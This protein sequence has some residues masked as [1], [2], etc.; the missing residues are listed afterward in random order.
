MPTETYSF[1]A[2]INQLMSLIINTFYSNKDIYLRELISNASDAIDK[3]KYN[4]LQSENVVRDYYIKLVADKEKHTLSIEDNGIG[5][6]KQD[7]ID[8]LGTVANS[9]TKQFMQALKEGTDVSLIGQFGVGFYSAYLVADTVSVY[10]GNHCWESK[11]GGSFTIEYSETPFIENGT[12]LVLH[13][14]ED[15]LD[16]LEQSN[17]EQIV[18]THS[19]YINYPISLWIT[20]TETKEVPDD[21]N[22][23]VQDESNETD[24][25]V[26]IEDV[27]EEI[28]EWKQINVQKPLWMRKPE[29]VNEEEHASFYKS[30][31]KDWDS[32]LA[33]KHFVAEGQI[34]FKSLLYIPK[35]SPHD[36]FSN[37][38]K[39]N[40][41]KLYVK[42]VFIMDNCE[43]LMP[44][45]LNFMSGVVDSEDL[46]LNISREILQQNKI[47]NV[48]KK[49]LVKKC[50][51]LFNELMEK[52]D[53]SLY[54]TFYDNYHQSLKLGVHEDSVNRDKLIKLLC[55]QTK[56]HT[57]K[58]ALSQYVKEM[59]SDQEHI[60]FITGESRKAV[61]NS[62]FVKG[63][64][65][66]GFD[67]V[68]FVDPIDE[69]MVQQVKEFES[70]K[71]LNISKDNSIF[72]EKN[73]DY[74]THLCKVLKNN[75]NIEKVVV[76]T[77]LG[78]DPCC[79]V[80]S[81]YGWSANMERIMKAQ[82]LQNNM[83]M[84]M[85][86]GSK[87]ILEVNPNHKLIQKLQDGIKNS[88]ISDKSIKDISNLIY[89]TAL[90]SS[91]FTHED[92]SSFSKRIYN[93]IAVGLDVEETT[94]TV[95]DTTEKENENMESEKIENE[96]MV[97]ESMEEID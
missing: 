52:E 92:P 96:N 90:L 34:E 39:K 37:K 63:I 82:T 74:E 21:S 33:H 78:E 64:I 86:Q 23:D 72:Q 18:H 9:G 41:I 46:P 85:M 43:E 29:D 13:M 61:E 31:T 51:E 60:Y 88:S 97:E 62:P 35:R 5:L 38:T 75:L 91:G 69:Y 79:L 24:S 4:A 14:K 10:S 70:V 57:S 25:N 22:D 54:N 84:G 53:K 66:K 40:N 83:H 81:E 11:A 2:E 20:R 58:I 48:I 27:S 47:T 8:C 28:Q 12:K 67:V 45:W 94:E 73:E 16:Y 44:D 95:E 50:I 3:A 56:N 65:N 89:D 15:C 59:K 80:S 42:R 32:H 1:Q 55:F 49:N 77:R 30:L 19:E 7:M 76:S 71:L 68:F 26:K 6:S 87:K 93:M 36:M 17:I